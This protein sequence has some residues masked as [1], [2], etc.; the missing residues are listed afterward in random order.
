MRMVTNFGHTHLEIGK[1]YKG[2]NDGRNSDSEKIY[3]HI[4]FQ[5][6]RNRS[7]EFAPFVPDYE[8]D[9][10]A[11]Y[12]A[13]IK[14]VELGLENAIAEICKKAMHKEDGIISFPIGFAVNND[15]E[16]AYFIT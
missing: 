9:G 13:E 11:Y 12:S 8:F 4:N 7:T 3:L 14:P 15:A 1:I 2:L 5:K 10:G 16:Y 6:M